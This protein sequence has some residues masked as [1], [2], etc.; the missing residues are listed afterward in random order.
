MA[1]VTRIEFTNKELLIMMLKK[2]EIHEG[3]WV[4]QAKLSF[5][6]MNMGTTSD[7]T[8]TMPAGAVA[9]SGMGLELVPEPLPFSVN[10]AEVNPKN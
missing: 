8:D 5:A 1:D 2:Q 9:V 10:A 4:I 6:A 7:G 3:N